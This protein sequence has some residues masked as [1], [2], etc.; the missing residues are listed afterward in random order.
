M[1]SPLPPRGPDG[2]DGTGRTDLS[3]KYV[4]TVLFLNLLNP[5]VF[6]SFSL[7]IG[8]SKP[9]MCARWYRQRSVLEHDDAVLGQNSPG[10]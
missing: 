8:C 10:V 5:V 4:L 3:P 7:R 1:R 6:F 9:P 2:Q